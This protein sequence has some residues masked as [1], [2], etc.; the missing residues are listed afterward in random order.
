MSRPPRRRQGDQ[1]NARRAVVPG[2]GAVEGR[3]QAPHPGAALL[4]DRQRAPLRL[5]ATVGR[6]AGTRHP[7]AAEP[8]HRLADPGRH[9]VREVALMD[10][11]FITG[12]A[13]FVSAMLVFVGSAFLLLALILGPKLAY[14]VTASITLAFTLIMGV[15]WSIN[16]LGPLGQSPEW[17]P[18]DAQT[19]TS[20]LEFPEAEQ[21]PDDPWTPPNTDD[22][23]QAT[24][25]SEL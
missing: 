14:F 20:A 22:A 16:P 25:A 5:Y 10:T 18:I 12:M 4:H 19:D 7:G 9:E 8:A 17:E 6:S 21:Y 24:Q 1:G 23:L 2:H 11:A 15:V 13:A 3:R